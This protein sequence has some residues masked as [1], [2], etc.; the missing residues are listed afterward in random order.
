MR[1]LSKLGRTF[2]Y[3]SPKK[4]WEWQVFL[5]DLAP[6][7]SIY[8]FRNRLSNI[9][10]PLLFELYI[11]IGFG[12][13][14][15]L[16]HIFVFGY[17][18]LK[19]TRSISGKKEKWTFKLV[20]LSFFIFLPLGII[21]YGLMILFILNVMAFPIV[22]LEALVLNNLNFQAGSEFPNIWSYLAS[23]S[24]NDQLIFAGCFAV[25][26]S[27]HGLRTISFF[28]NPGIRENLKKSQWLFFGMESPPSQSEWTEIEESIHNTIQGDS[29]WYFYLGFL[30]LAL[31]VWSSRYSFF[32]IFLYFNKA[33]FELQWDRLH[34]PIR[35]Q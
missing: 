22:Y 5:T 25:A 17:D 2:L 20:F 12:M 13:L 26:L 16:A 7:L 15:W 27:R 10:I 3:L 18:Y 34:R 32:P 28:R 21:L 35:K 30:W 31:A 6:L 24:Q 29:H 11:F 4:P 14:K 9:Y 8:F 1:I 19:K 23:S 33:L